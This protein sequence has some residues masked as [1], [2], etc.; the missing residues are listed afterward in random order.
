MGY[1]VVVVDDEV[2]SLT[3]ARSILSKEDMRVSCLRSGGD[4]LEFMEN[5]SPDLILMDILMPE[6]DGFETYDALRR[7]EKENGRKQ[8]PVIF[9]TGENDKETEKRGLSAGASD[10][11]HKPF[12]KDILVSRIQNTI[13]NNKTIESLT[14][15]ATVDKLTGFLNKATGTKSVSQLCG[16]SAGVFMIMDLDN[17]KLV[18][19]LFGHD[20]GD[21]VL[22]AYAKIV[23]KNTR[24]TDVVG[25]IGGDEFIA[26]FKNVSEEAAIES[27]S[28]RLNKELLDET[29]KILGE[30]NGIPIGISIGAV[31]IPEHGRN[32]DALFALA[33]AALYTVKQNGKHGYMVHSGSDIEK[34]ADDDLDLEIE[35]IT[36]IIGARNVKHGAIV[37]GSE[38]FSDVYRF[39]IPY[40]KRYGGSCAKILFSLVSEEEPVGEMFKDVCDQF[41]V[42]LQRSLRS[43]DLIMQ[44]RSNQYFAFLN[45]RKSFEVENVI[46]R[47]LDWWTKTEYGKMSIKIKYAFK[48]VDYPEEK[49]PGREE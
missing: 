11:I 33:D 14:E 26:F 41:G 13:I 24:D 35:R 5:N 4:F 3:N 48:Y 31:M 28:N 37:L 30:D 1:W 10:F 47:I 32:Y 29:E 44:Y 36:Q 17:F 43:C 20:M 23:R 42:T 34:F 40:Y 8:T 19:D 38:A 12:D 16:E 22:K 39:I 7:F 15:E 6:M 46:G 49:R 45:E 27:L 9:L 18:N 2:L 25:R 21:R